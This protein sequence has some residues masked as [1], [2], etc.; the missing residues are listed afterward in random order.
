MNHKKVA[1]FITEGPTDQEFYKA[2]I[3]KTKALCSCTRFNANIEF[4]CASGI[5]RIY[6]K[7]VAKFKHEIVQNDKYKGYRFVVFLCYDK[8]VFKAF[9]NNP[10]IDVE[11]VE[12]GLKSAGADEIHRIVADSMIEDW[13]VEDTNGIR[14]FLGLPKKYKI[15]KGLKGIALLQRMYK[16]ADSIYAKGTRCHGLIDHLNIPLIAYKHCDSLKLICDVL[17]FDCKGNV[18][19]EAF[20][21]K[22]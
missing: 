3:D 21:K 7:A 17:G 6:S 20:D 11:E 19:K 18:C 14:E 9:P 15:P 22:K 12:K 2:F 10:P 5:G 16:D 13:L 1:V 8:D 4:I